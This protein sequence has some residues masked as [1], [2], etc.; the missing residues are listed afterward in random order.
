MIAPLRKRNCMLLIIDEMLEDTVFRDFNLY[1][2]NTL[3]MI[4]FNQHLY[5]GTGEI[6][7]RKETL[8]FKDRVDLV[9]FFF[10]LY[11]RSTKKPNGK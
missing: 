6:T 5:V 1:S 4:T 11:A 10:L 8:V 9:L 7:S 3:R 2:L